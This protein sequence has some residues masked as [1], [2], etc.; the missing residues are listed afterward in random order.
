MFLNKIYTIPPSKK[1]IIIVF[2]SKIYWDK[3]QSLI[4]VLSYLYFFLEICCEYMFR[5]I[6]HVKSPFLYLKVYPGSGKPYYNRLA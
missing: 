1:F 3:S 6:S 2:F 5:A 4:F